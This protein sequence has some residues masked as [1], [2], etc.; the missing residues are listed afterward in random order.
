MNRRRARG[1]RSRRRI[2]PSISYVSRPSRWCVRGGTGSRRSCPRLVTVGVVETIS[3]HSS[4][5]PLRT[6]WTSSPVPFARVSPRVRVLRL[7]PRGVSPRRSRRPR[8][9]DVVSRPRSSSR[10][11][12][13]GPS[14]WPPRPRRGRRPSPNSLVLP[15]LWRRTTR[16]GGVFLP[17]TKI[18]RPFHSL[19]LLEAHAR[20]E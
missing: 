17:D 10:R 12:P 1:D 19:S 4:S 2:A 7:S 11:S 6:S 3:P 14:R 18:L 9:V 20:Q 13:S 15:D 16:G 5:P 8:R